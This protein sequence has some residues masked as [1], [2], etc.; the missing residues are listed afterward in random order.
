VGYVVFFAVAVFLGGL[1]FIAA[2]T[3]RAYKQVR[4]LGR[5]VADASE[6]IAAATAAL[7]TVAPR[8]R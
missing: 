5:T 4:A 7:E 6:R 8:E 1:L 3:V 2:L